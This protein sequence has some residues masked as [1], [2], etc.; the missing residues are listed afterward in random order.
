MNNLINISDNMYLYPIKVTGANN[1]TKTLIVKIIFDN[2]FVI[3]EIWN[4]DDNE[5]PKKMLF[6]EDYNKNN[7]NFIYVLTALNVPTIEIIH[8]LTNE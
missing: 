8:R 1:I 5:R 4:I 2:D 7:F 3:I 6:R